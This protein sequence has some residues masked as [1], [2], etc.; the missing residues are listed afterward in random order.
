MYGILSYC[1]IRFDIYEDLLV[2]LNC[3]TK[4]R[5][6]RDV[7]GQ[8]SGHLPKMRTQQSIIHARE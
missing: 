3:N 2:W 4:V 5:Y 1:N 6:M 7:Y 8:M